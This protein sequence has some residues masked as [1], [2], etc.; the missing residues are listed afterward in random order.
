MKHEVAYAL[1]P[2]ARIQ[3]DGAPI[4]RTDVQPGDQSGAAVMSRKVADDVGREPFAPE[5]RHM[6]ADQVEQPGLRPLARAVG[7]HDAAGIKELPAAV[8]GSPG[9]VVTEV[10]RTL[11]TPS[12]YYR[13]PQE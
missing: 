7:D 11:M 13:T 4:G 6:L 8:W 5:D 3:I 2:Q 10:T 9:F 12:T 1:E